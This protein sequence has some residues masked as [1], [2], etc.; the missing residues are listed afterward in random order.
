MDRQGEVGF[1][2]GGTLALGLGGESESDLSGPDEPTLEIGACA[3]HRPLGGWSRDIRGVSVRFHPTGDLKGTWLAASY[4][5]SDDPSERGLPAVGAGAWARRGR[6][7]FTMQ[8]VQLLGHVTTIRRDIVRP[9]G[10]DTLTTADPRTRVTEVHQDDVRL[11]S[12]AEASA[13]YATTRVELQSRFGIVVGL[14][15]RP[16]QWGELRA[17]FW[18][19]RNLAAFARV[20]TA[21]GVP[22]ALESVRGTTGALGL[23]LAPGRVFQHASQDVSHAETF[24]MRSLGDGRYAIAI[25]TR[26]HQVELCSDATEWSPMPAHPVGDGAWEVVLTMAPGVHRIAMRV[27]GGPWKP[28]PGLPTTRDE[29]GGAVALIVVE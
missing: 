22:S 8:T 25:R 24:T 29:F 21:D 7:L 16:A 10:A 13:G 1:T 26:G 27:D 19:L 2:V 28:V 23:Q 15:E 9:T 4:Q 20:R 6:F 18:A 12:G 5:Q 17:A 11:F 3:A 14:H